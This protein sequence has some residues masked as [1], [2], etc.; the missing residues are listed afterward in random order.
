MQN[1]INR[2]KYMKNFDIS[3]LKKKTNDLSLLLTL[4]AYTIPNE[5]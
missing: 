5:C 3:D 2:H 4:A 1:K